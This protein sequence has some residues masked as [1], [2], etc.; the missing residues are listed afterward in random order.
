MT[1]PRLR[2]RREALLAEPGLTGTAWCRTY[3]ER[4]DEWLREVFAAA[5]GGE[6][7][8][9]LLAVGGYGGGELAPGSDLDLVLVHEQRHPPTKVA[10]AMWY[11]IWDEG[12]HLDHSVRNLKELRGAMGDDLKVALGWLQARMV[13]GDARL[14]GEAIS[15]A[16]ELWRT[17]APKWLPLVDASVRERHES[18]GDLAFLLEPDIKEAR[19]GSR[20]I[21][22]L[23]AVARVSPV[24]A[25]VISAPGLVS[26]ADLLAAVRVELQRATG[27]SANRLLLQDQDV[28][29]G[30]LGYRD[31]DKLMLDVAAAGRTIAWASDDGWRRVASWLHGPRGREH[32]RD[33]PVE[34]GVVLRDG[35]VALS[36]DADPAGDPSLA[37]RLAAAS[38]ELDRPM[39]RSALDRLASEAVAPEGA[40]PPELLRALLRVLGAGRPGVTAIESLDQIGVWLR[41][42]PEWEAVRSRPQRNAY[43]RFTVDRHLL[44]TAANASALT[45]Q[46]SRPDLLLAG[47]LLH[48]IG[49]GRGGDHTDVGIALLQEL[50]PRMGFDVADTAVLTSMVRHHL[51]LPDAATRRDL[52]DPRTIEMVADAAG[53]TTTLELLAALTEADSLATG[54]SAWGQWKAGLVATLTARAAAHLAGQPHTPNQVPLSPEEQKL[55]DAGELGLSAE[56]GRVT[57]AAPDRAGLLSAVAGTLALNGVTVRS[58]STRTE[59]GSRMAVLSFDVVPTFDVL[60]NWSKVCDQLRAALDGRLPLAERL[61]ERER[62]YAGRRRPTAAHRPSVTVSTHHDA[63]TAATVFEV[64]APDAGHVLFHI[65]QAIADAGMLID[66]ALV[67]TLGAEVVDAFYVTTAAGEKLDAGAADALSEDITAALQ[68]VVPEHL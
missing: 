67:S 36:V 14:A 59:P 32:A 4:C 20:D 66:A 5:T 43:H 15:R 21:R 9:A 30:A 26:A 34:P 19:G 60:P 16:D 2:A 68:P 53:D 29:A 57:V 28:V 63:A 51:L 44:E 23:H 58:A 38:A 17:R 52:D 11:P 13:A 33:R 62:T 47:A 1:T 41:L 10:E 40:W 27:K 61:A 31:A 22:L 49:K 3:A 24:L 46:V 7:G 25:G 35:E 18:Y 45:R 55:V 37:L 56:G 6:S 50:A 65:T 54:P 12:V 39:A 48:D 42:L 8:L 64:R